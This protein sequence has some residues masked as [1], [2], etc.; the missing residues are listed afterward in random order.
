MALAPI[1]RER[2]QRPKYPRTC[3]DGSRVS[4]SSCQTSAR[5]DAPS[6]LRGALSAGQADSAPLRAGAKNRD[7][8]SYTGFGWPALT[9]GAELLL[10]LL[11][12]LVHGVGLSE[13]PGF[14]DLRGPLLVHAQVDRERVVLQ[15]V[16]PHPGPA[17]RVGQVDRLRGQGGIEFGG[18]LAPW[19]A[20]EGER[21]ALD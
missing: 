4:S 14:R 17:L 12:P 21:V 6:D 1:Q 15:L 19:R 18:G 7:T 10:L 3:K 2:R 5:R 9:A 8:N 11:G 20:R 13:D 16:G